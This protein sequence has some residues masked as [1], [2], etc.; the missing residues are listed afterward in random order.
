MRKIKKYA[1]LIIQ[2]GDTYTLSDGVYKVL[3][4][5]SKMLGASASTLYL[6][7]KIYHMENV[8]TKE[9]KYIPISELEKELPKY[10]EVVQLERKVS[11]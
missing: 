8:E 1:D 3:T 5:T 6:G 9:I 10:N 4:A 11:Q 2:I 7:K